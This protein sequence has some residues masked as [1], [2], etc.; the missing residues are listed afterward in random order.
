MKKIFKLFV[1]SIL[2]FTVTIGAVFAQRGSSGA[3]V[4]NV[5][6]VSGLPRNSDWGRALD[7]LAADWARV[8]NNQV[9]VIMTHGSQMSE[10]TLLSSLRSNSIQVGVFTSAGIFDICPAIMNLSVPFMIRNNDELDFVLDDVLPILE[11]RVREEFVIIAWS[12]GGW[13]YV[14][15]K[16]PVYSPYDLRRL[17]LAT[18]AELTDMNTVFR[19]MGFNMIETDWSN[20]GTRLASNM[21]TAFYF[22]PTLI[23]PMNLHRGLNM[24]DLPITPIMGA[25]VMNRVTWNKLSSAHQQELLRVTRTLATEFD[26]AMLRSEVNAKTTMERGGLI[27]NRPTQAQQDLWRS[28]LQNAI[29]SLVGSIYDRELYTRINSILER[30][31][32]R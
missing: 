24:L 16:E 11:S 31:R 20:I 2:L 14:F 25:I 7:R 28:D 26:N 6:F 32:G 27:V 9:N 3:Q 15:S 18:S 10:G 19:T 5:R 1:I 23:T 30:A 12:K 21:I 22:I 4:T 13:L 17:R 29:P 8:T